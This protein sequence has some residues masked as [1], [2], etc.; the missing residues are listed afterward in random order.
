MDTSPL[1]DPKGLISGINKIYFEA[2]DRANRILL[3]CAVQL[4]L[5]ACAGI[6]ASGDVFVASKEEKERIT[7][8][9]SASVCEME[10]AAIA[11]A[12]FVNGIPFA[13]IRA[14]S[15]N[16]DGQS[17]MDFPTFLKQAAEASRALTL[18]LVE[19]Y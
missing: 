17:H 1:G 11:Q 3:D 4:G 2:D 16:A 13:V 12:A 7:R 8:D 5:K 10:G 9:F 14:I 15:D 19:K 18:A 6:I